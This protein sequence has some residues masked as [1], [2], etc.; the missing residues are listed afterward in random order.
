MR[1][2]LRNFSRSW[3]EIHFFRLVGAVEPKSLPFCEI[4][5]RLARTNLHFFLFCLGFGF[6]WQASS[7]S[8]ERQATTQHQLISHSFWLSLFVFPCASLC[9]LQHPQHDFS[10]PTENDTYFEFETARVHLSVNVKFHV[11]SSATGIIRQPQPAQSTQESWTAFPRGT[12]RCICFPKERKQTRK[13]WPFVVLRS[14]RNFEQPISREG[15][16]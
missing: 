8:A 6:D 12:F 16:T 13:G 2:E 5:I 7:S 15:K 9:T 1:S 14:G 4:Q 3:P 11:Q 10:F